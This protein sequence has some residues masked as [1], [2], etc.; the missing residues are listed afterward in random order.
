MDLGN[1]RFLGPG[2]GL[3]GFIHNFNKAIKY[4]SYFATMIA[5]TEVI[6]N[7]YRIGS[8]RLNQWQW[9]V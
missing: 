5:K 6:Y 8:R 2:M 1:P 4:K 3:S 9:I 7:K